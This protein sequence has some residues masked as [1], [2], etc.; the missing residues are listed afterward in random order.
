MQIGRE[1][2]EGENAGDDDNERNDQFEHRGKND[3]LLTFCK[4]LGTEG[5]LHDVLIET[6]VK[7]VRNPEANE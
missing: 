2:I 1:K 5:S 4:G 6:P 7:K 3:T